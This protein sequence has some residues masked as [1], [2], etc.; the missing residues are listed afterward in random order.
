MT[1]VFSFA[2][3]C[4]RSFSVL[5]INSTCVCVSWTLLH[6]SSVPLFMVVQWSPTRKQ[7]SEL[8]SGDTWARLPYTDHP[9]YLRGDV[10]VF[11]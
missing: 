6:N 7:D 9:T 2:G 3:R 10:I 1:A 5:V 8:H 11:I 4:V